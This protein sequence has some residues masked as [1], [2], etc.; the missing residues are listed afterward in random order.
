MAFNVP[1]PAMPDK[2]V[3]VS[4]LGITTPNNWPAFTWNAASN[5][6]WYLLWVNDSTGNRIHKWYSEATSCSG[7]TCSAAPGIPLASGAVSWWV[8]SWSP[9]GYGPWSDTGTFTAPAPVV[10]GKVTP[11]SP[12]GSISTTTPAFSWNA[13]AHAS[14]Y[15]LWVSDSTGNK[16]SRWYTAVQAGCGSGT[17]NCSVVPGSALAPGSGMW[18]VDTWNPN[19]AGPWSNGMIFTVSV[20]SGLNE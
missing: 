12:S 10:P 18:W 5:T 13:D 2:V 1:T 7:G 3:L 15:W 6:T 14:W 8:Q 9:N 4:P 11:V 17:G 20:G 16:I 19:G